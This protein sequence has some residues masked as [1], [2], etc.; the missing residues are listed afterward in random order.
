MF[1]IFIHI[2]TIAGK[3][4]YCMVSID[5][6][7]WANSGIGSNM[8]WITIDLAIGSAGYWMLIL[9]TGMIFAKVRYCFSKA[10]FASSGNIAASS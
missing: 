5:Y 1:A 6:P 4:S 9:R 10:V 8:M 2:D 7:P 3:V